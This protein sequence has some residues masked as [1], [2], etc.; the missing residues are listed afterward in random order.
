MTSSPSIYPLSRE[1]HSGLGWR[2][3][4]DYGFARSVAVAPLSAAEVT[5]AAL[6]LPVAL[7]KNSNDQW[8]V[9]AVLGLE[10]QQNLFIGAD[11]KWL[12]AYVP[13]TLRSYPFR[14]GRAEEGGDAMLCI[15]E[16][17]GLLTEDGGEPFFMDSGEPSAAIG[18]IWA[19]VQ[20]V[21]D[22]E[23][24]LSHASRHLGAAG[25]IE[26]W[27]ITVKDGE[28]AR[29]VD[30]LHRVS[31]SALN[32]LNDETF[33]ELR[34]QGILGLAYAQM[35]STGHLPKLGEMFETQR[36]YASLEAERQRTAASNAGHFNFGESLNVDWSQFDGK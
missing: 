22:G 18:D 8:Q 21:A 33:V 6:A 20:E 27:P 10:P 19:F 36:R 34:R 31:E 13:A 29:T 24:R 25:I 16:A 12:G 11:G 23:V 26:P 5:K 35:F 32:G 7:V 3:F 2:R 30:G 1:R 15:D 4:S 14:V 28:I 17:S 9:V